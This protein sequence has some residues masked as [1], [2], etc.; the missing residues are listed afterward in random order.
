MVRLIYSMAQME[1]SFRT[2]PQSP[3]LNLY[4]ALLWK[5]YLHIRLEGSLDNRCENKSKELKWLTQV[6]TA[7]GGICSKRLQNQ[8]WNLICFRLESVL[9]ALYSIHSFLIIILIFQ[10]KVQSLSN[11]CVIKRNASKIS[12]KHLKKPLERT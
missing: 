5:T 1:L 12:R 2:H 6:H 8:D 7:S 10:K 11:S 9:L 4:P 3:A